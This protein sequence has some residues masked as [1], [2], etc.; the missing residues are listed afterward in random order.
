MRWIMKLK[1]RN[2]CCACLILVMGLLISMMIPAEKVSAAGTTLQV[3]NIDYDSETIT[4]KSSAGDKYLYFS[5]AKQT[6]W[7]CAYGT[8]SSGVYVLDISWVSKTKDYTLTLKGD[9]ST[10][11]LEVVLPKQPAALKATYDYETEKL[12]ITGGSGTIYW[13]KSTSTVWT[14]MES[15]TEME[16]IVKRFYAKGI[17]LYFR[18][19]STDGTSATATG[20]RPSKEAKLKITKQ[21]S[22][23]KT[24][25]NM[26]K[27][28]ITKNKSWEYKVA[29][30]ASA[31]A[32]AKWTT[33]K[34]TSLS[35][36]EV[37]KA[38]YY[39]GTT[40]GKDVILV[41]RVPATKSKLP[42]IQ[43]QLVVK[44]QEAAPAN[45]VLG[46]A[47]STSCTITVAESKDTSGKVW[48]AASETNP[49]EYTIVT[50][51]NGATVTTI[52]TDAE[53]KEIVS[54]NPVTI[55]EKNAPAG[56]MIYVRKKAH[57]SGDTIYLES[58]IK[59][60]KV[61][62]YPEAS[63]IAL[64]GAATD[65]VYLKDSKVALVKVEGKEA[66]GL[67][68]LVTTSKLLD[69]TDVKSIKCN[70]KNLE[71]TT[72]VKDNQI[73]VTITS[74]EAFEKAVST[75]N[76]AYAVTV[77]LKNGEKLEDMV[78]LTV[79]GKAELVKEKAI[80]V[81][82]MSNNNASYEFDIL[83]G[84]MTTK[85][86]SGEYIKTTVKEVWL[87]GKNVFYSAANVTSA[88]QTVTLSTALLQECFDDEK[89]ELKK[90][91]T[92][93]IVMDDGQE[94][95]SGITVVFKEAAEASGESHHF[96]K[97]VG[98][99]MTEHIELKMTYSD[100]SLYVASATWNGIDLMGNA[101]SGSK[102]TLSL[103]YTKINQLTLPEGTESLTY[104]V[105]ITLNNG[106]I[107]T[108]EYTLTLTK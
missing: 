7:E 32:S 38:A 96:V 69:A 107:V 16:G 76:K 15:F 24:V 60:L 89:I 87:E 33:D 49:Y 55:S 93:K 1:K 82:H 68:F 73:C 9:K 20:T 52:P 80:E 47:S 94:I 8:F 108:R 90:E 37:A 57:N 63:T 98:T 103:D 22:A 88:Q 86:S 11:V 18:T 48:E 42:S 41:F 19:G 13:R 99:D 10:G 100:D 106:A 104:P 2:V 36:P 29:L 54:E 74:A 78:T 67:S 72:T 34:L 105:V 92:V 14:K 75:R 56:S 31:V 27:L 58:L 40:A 102:L 46:Y 17:T 21:A 6:T 62:E 53:W 28:T 4:I 3:T 85:D 77:V 81:I 26:T 25:I 95:T 12:T 101:T 23:P 30:S 64:N 65:A 35:I 39:S 59:S 83:P 5:D 50:P 84:R 70:D 51:V 79:L 91:Y 44:A 61:T 43:R 71:F 45:V 97:K 66:E